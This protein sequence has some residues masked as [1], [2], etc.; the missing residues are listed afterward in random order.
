M[1]A[2]YLDMK[3]RYGDCVLFFRLGDFYE[4]FFDEA[5]RM[6]AELDL[7][8]TARDCG[9]DGR[10]PMCGIPYHSAVGY[11]SKLIAKGYK[12]ALCEQVEDPRSAKGLVRRAVTRV[13]TPGTVMD[14]TMLEERKN[15]YIACVYGQGRAYG[16]AALDV[17]TGEVSCMESGPGEGHSG[18][19]DEIA[20]FRPSE[21]LMN[22]GASRSKGME[23]VGGGFG[24]YVS[25]LGEG[26]FDLGLIREAVGGRF[27]TGLMGRDGLDLGVCAAGALVRYVGE[28]G[29]AE[30][31]HLTRLTRFG[32]GESMGMDA[33]TRR[34][35]E[36]TEPMHGG[37][38]KDTLAG[39]LD[40][41]ATPM[42]S[43]L[44]KRMVGSPL[45]DAAAINA[46]LDA[47]A[48]LWSDY[49][50]AGELSQTLRSMRD[51]E[52]LICKIAFAGGNCRDMVA[53]KESCRVLPSVKRSLSRY[54][55][56]ELSSMAEG[57]DELAD[58][59][60]LIDRAIKDDPPISVT[61]GGILKEGFDA[62]AD[63]LREAS[64]KGRDWVVAYEASE[65]ARTGIKGL[66]TGYNRV[67]GYYIEVP[68][69]QSHLAPEGYA[70]K[71]TLA[72]GERYVTGEL[73]EMEGRI[74]DAEARLSGVE[75]EAYQRVRAE[76][77]SHLAR[78][79]DVGGLIAL[80]DVYLSFAECSREYGYVRPEVDDGLT[81]ELRGARHPVVERAGPMGGFVPNDLLV[82]T[83]DNRFLIITGPNMA[84]KSTYMRQAALVAVMAQCGCFVPCDYARVGIV[85]RLFTRVGAADDLAAGK[86]TF[87]VEMTEMA[88]ILSNATERSLIL[89]DEIGRGTGTFDGLSI[90]WAVT[91]HISSKV[92]GRT[93]LATHYREL[94]ELEGKL[95]GVVNMR[96]AVRERGEDI[97]FLRKI[98]R[99]G[100]DGSY[101]IHVARLAGIPK[102]VTDRAEEVLGE[103]EDAS[104]GYANVKVRKGG[105]TPDGQLDVLS[106]NSAVRVSDELARM[107][108]GL[109]L[110]SVSPREALNLLYDIQ[111]S[112][113]A[114]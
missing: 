36:L 4:M 20:R 8:L 86:S 60:G 78:I 27:G 25:V 109:D 83:R 54:V 57:L 39:V 50:G 65:K 58:V 3:E 11:I 106:Y 45:T 7:A 59:F 71:Q 1:I 14:P 93:M 49:V 96:A 19:L 112:L 46:R 66:K 79:K 30:P 2:Q 102:A 55:G 100:A 105:R 47:V 13:V 85:D 53:L 69:S 38:G 91:E 103:L 35:L 31:I 98:E 15:N 63:G 9:D 77:T 23:G 84:G 43:R 76:L 67:F 70:R 111:Q 28:A 10:A 114:N 24:A 107:V 81:L 62:E 73:A 42:G 61:E 108:G 97:V 68:R 101:G 21:I 99:G 37:R 87:M 113:R 56:G 33:G 64:V 90:A 80:L 29:G 16:L 18:L 52:R 89:L 41:T 74:L 48:E 6:S 32:R 26:A 40:R 5:V 92:R 17:T 44:L 22:E 104:I 72:G 95:D 34:N 82:D 51:M 88:N 75:H 110:S 94:T 12:V